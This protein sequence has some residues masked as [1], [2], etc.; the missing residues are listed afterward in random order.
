MRLGAEVDPKRQK[1]TAINLSLKA[2]PILA[3]VRN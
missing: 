3:R 1:R 2:R